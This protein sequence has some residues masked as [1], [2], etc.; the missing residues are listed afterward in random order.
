MNRLHFARHLLSLRRGPFV[1]IF[2]GV[3]ATGVVQPAGLISPALA[4]IPDHEIR[5]EDSLSPAWKGTWDRARQLYREH[6]YRESL[7]QYEILLAQKENLAEARWEYASILLG[8][9]RWQQAAKQLETLLA[10][11]PGNRQYRMA[12]A[13]VYLETGKRARSIELYRQLYNSD[14]DGPESTPA[15]EGLV[16]ALEESGATSELAPYLE[17]LAARK[18]ADM[19]L[20]RKF[21]ALLLEIGRFEEARA[22][23]NSLEKQGAEEAAF[24]DLQAR[25]HDRAGDEEAAGRY[26]QKLVDRDR[27]H[28]EA[29]RWLQAYY[30]GKKDWA[31][32]LKHLEAVLR[33]TPDDPVLLE[34]AASLNMKLGRVDAA[35]VCYE[36]G[37]ALKPEDLHM[38]NG[39]KGA[40]RL[41]ALNLLPLVEN[42]GSQKLW[43]D[44]AQVTADRAGVFREIAALLREKDHAEQLVDVLALLW[45][46]NPEDL[47]AYREL[48]VLLARTGRDGELK[49]LQRQST[50]E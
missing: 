36:N 25:V 20:Q 14:P 11:D 31:S 29:N 50:V 6:K 23:L 16:R 18:S 5:Y 46:E 22:I 43:Q 19:E 44:L 12:A 33:S 48:V 28:L 1:V 7:V 27:D 24:D 39:K 34:Q 45:R 15:L 2:C 49:N 47:P 10:H 21:A 32:C 4:G 42:G 37:L 3:V 38:Q 8:Q 35:L 30:A 13:R 9:K 26:W 17:N 40:Q 41:M